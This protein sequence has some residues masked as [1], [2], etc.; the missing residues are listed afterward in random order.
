MREDSG[1][2]YLHGPHAN[3]SWC[4]VICRG[5]APRPITHKCMLQVQGS[6]LITPQAKK[7]S[8]CSLQYLPNSHLMHTQCSSNVHLVQGYIFFTKFLTM[9]CKWLQILQ[10]LE[11]IYRYTFNNF[12]ESLRVVHLEVTSDWAHSYTEQHRYNS[13]FSR[14]YS[15]KTPHSSPV[16]ARYGVFFVDPAS[17]WYSPSDPAIIHVI[18]YNIGQCYNGTRLYYLLITSSI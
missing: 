5:A 11:S 2:C 13:Q 14:K 3:N 4:C 16:R 18:S 10:L 9:H 17:E 12:Q 1:K 15:E 8:C 6:M 7:F